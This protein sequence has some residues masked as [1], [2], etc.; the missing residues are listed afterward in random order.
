M[1][2]H[3]VHPSPADRPAVPGE[4]RTWAMIAHGA[5]LAAMAFS[6]GFLGFVGS[7][8]V[9]L[10]HKDD[11]PFIRA[12]AANSLNIQ[13]TTLF[14]LIVAWPLI[15]LLGLGLVILFVAPVIALVLHVVGLLKAAGGELWDPP[16][17][18]RLVR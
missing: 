8:V 7:L 9:F 4:Q 2:E 13:L 17:V 3:T 5:A 1:S 12:H 10:T 14:W 16:L 15:L 18:P 6:A 11:G